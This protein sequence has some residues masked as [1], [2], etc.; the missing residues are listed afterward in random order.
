MTFAVSVTMSVAMAVSVVMS[1]MTL[2]EEHLPGVVV[3][4]IGEDSVLDIAAEDALLGKRHS[5][6]H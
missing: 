3:S 2:T 4:Y 1:V 5:I 6:L